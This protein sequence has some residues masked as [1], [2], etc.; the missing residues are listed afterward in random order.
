M[1][2]VVSGK[3]KVRRDEC[4]RLVT[5]FAKFQARGLKKGKLYLCSWYSAYMKRL[6][7]QYEGDTK[8]CDYENERV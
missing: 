6:H 5:A 4:E 7:C 8:C 1:I 3:G 2:K